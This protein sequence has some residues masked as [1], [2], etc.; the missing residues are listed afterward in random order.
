MDIE[1]PDKYRK[2]CVPVPVS[3]IDVCFLG[4][5]D[6]DHVAMSFLDGHH[7]RRVAGVVAAV[8]VG[9]SFQ[10]A[11]DA[12]GIT[13]ERQVPK[14]SSSIFVYAGALVPFRKTWHV[15]SLVQ[16]RRRSETWRFRPRVSLTMRV[17]LLRRAWAP[18]DRLAGTGA[19]R[20]R[21]R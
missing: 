1:V 10:S 16:G 12:I 15:T 17:S 19:R 13:F 7:Q 8:G 6:F 3:P 18:R 11:A 2:S 14:R 4:Y 20:C 5:E 9:P 21:S